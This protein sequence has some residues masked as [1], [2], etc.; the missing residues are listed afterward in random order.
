MN[1]QT[2]VM[3][4]VAL[5]LGMLLAHMLKGVC[6]CK[7]V[8]GVEDDWGAKGIFRE[9]NTCADKCSQ[10]LNSCVAP[11]CD[12]LRLNLKANYPL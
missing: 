7:V 11:A 2:I 3:C 4:V 1:T 5:I 6:G 8:E 9:D 12:S 10:Y